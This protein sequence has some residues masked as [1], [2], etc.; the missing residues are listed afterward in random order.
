MWLVAIEILRT[1][2]TAPPCLPLLAAAFDMRRQSLSGDVKMP[3]APSR[4]AET[5]QPLALRRAGLGLP[6]GCSRPS[7]IQDISVLFCRRRR[8]YA[9]AHLLTSSTALTCLR[10]IEDCN[11]PPTFSGHRYRG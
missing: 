9:S 6:R 1:K 7:R 10:D 2:R 8:A 3:G 4:I 5:A 11:S